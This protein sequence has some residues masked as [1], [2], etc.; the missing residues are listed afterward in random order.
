MKILSFIL[1]TNELTYL[2][3]LYQVLGEGELMFIKNIAQDMDHT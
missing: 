3:G 2:D 1:K